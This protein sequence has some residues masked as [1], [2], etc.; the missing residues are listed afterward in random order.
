MS[1]RRRP[2]V[3]RPHGL[4]RFVGSKGR[5]VSIGVAVGSAAIFIALPFVT[6]LY[7]PSTIGTTGVLLAVAGVASP[8]VSLGINPSMKLAHRDSKWLLLRISVVSV[9]SMFVWLPILL[10][11]LSSLGLVSDAPLLGWL[12]LAIYMVLTFVAESGNALATRR[13]DMNAIALSRFLQGVSTA[14]SQV[15]LGYLAPSV[16]S[17]LVAQSV[18]VGVASIAVLSRTLRR[19]DFRSTRGQQSPPDS[20]S[21]HASRP[22]FHASATIG[23]FVRNVTLQAPVLI[24]A[25]FYPAAVVGQ[26]V[27]AVRMASIPPSVLGVG[28]GLFL[29]AQASRLLRARSPGLRAATVEAVRDTAGLALLAYSVGFV[30]SFYF[31]PLLGGGFEEVGVYFRVLTPAFILQL[32]S[33]PIV[34]ILMLLA[35]GG[36]Y[37]TSMTIRSALGAGFGAVAAALGATPIVY[38]ACLSLG[39]ALGYLSSIALTVNACGKADETFRAAAGE[40]SLRAE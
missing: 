8:F 35:R 39:L 30:C 25:A 18:G 28:R 15:F 14:A 4:V 1:V 38:L 11:L 19:S 23:T 12:A 17:L 32:A 10:L 7:G 5:L 40:D 27:L 13:F 33:A 20:A 2:M 37:V 31:A 9:L 16:T 6:R 29:Q 24:A 22:G 3:L 26:I 34:M 21:N 36:T